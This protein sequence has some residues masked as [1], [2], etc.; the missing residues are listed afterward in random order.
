MSM[1]VLHAASSGGRSWRPT[2]KKPRFHAGVYRRVNWG[3]MIVSHGNKTVTIITSEVATY[4]E[5][6]N[7]RP[8]AKKSKRVVIVTG[9]LDYRGIPTNSYT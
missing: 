1:A 4:P 2:K 9:I 6:K 3:S 5:I 7:A 8:G